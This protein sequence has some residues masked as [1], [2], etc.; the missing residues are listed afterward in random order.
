VVWA[1]VPYEDDPAQGKDRPVVVVGR[2]LAGRRSDLVVLA[3]SSKDHADDPGWLPLGVGAWD[4]S[5]RTSFVRV[6]RVLSVGPEGIRRE[7]ATLD[8]A[9]FERVAEAASRQHGWA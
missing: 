5:G 4:R 2:A 6:D 3:L 8:R 7:G 9:R 1:W